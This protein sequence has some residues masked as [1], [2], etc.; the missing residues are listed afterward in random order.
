MTDLI[1]DFNESLSLGVTPGE[2]SLFESVGPIA[3]SFPP[4]VWPGREDSTVGQRMELSL[5][6][7]GGSRHRLCRDH[8]ERK[9]HLRPVLAVNLF[10]LGQNREPS[11]DTSDTRPSAVSSHGPQNTHGIPPK[12]K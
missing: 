3:P 11:L 7:R 12:C 5:C 4:C 10:R 8:F 2:S 6:V 1:P 9:G